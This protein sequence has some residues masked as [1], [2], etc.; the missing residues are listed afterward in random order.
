MKLSQNKVS[1]GNSSNMR[2]AKDLTKTFAAEM[3]A[4]FG[5]RSYAYSSANPHPPPS[6]VKPQ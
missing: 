3:S 5:V 4:I 6:H 2:D 1:E